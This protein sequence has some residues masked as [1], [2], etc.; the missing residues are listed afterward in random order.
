MSVPLPEFTVT[1]WWGPPTLLDPED[2]LPRVREAGFNV[3]NLP[4]YT[5]ADSRYE[6]SPTVEYNRRL[7]RAAEENG[8]RV[9]V[10][11]P[12]IRRACR[13]DA[14][15]SQ[16]R[17]L[18]RTVVSDYAGYAA[19]LGYYLA[20]EPGGQAFAPLAEVHARLKEAG[21]DALGYVNLLPNYAPAKWLGTDS[22]EEY[23]RRFAEAVRPDVLSYD[24]YRFGQMNS[25][26]SAHRDEQAQSTQPQF[27]DEIERLAYE[28]AHD[29]ADSPS[30]YLENLALFSRVSREYAIPF[31]LVGLLVTHGPYPYVP[32]PQIE[33]QMVHAVRYGARGFSYFSYWTPAHDDMWRW[34]DGAV[35]WDGSATGHYDDV[36]SVNQRVTNEL[37][38]RLAG[39][40]LV[41]PDMPVATALPGVAVAG[42]CRAAEFTGGLALV[43][44]VSLSAPAELWFDRNGAPDVIAGAQASVG[45]RGSAGGGGAITLGPGQAALIRRAVP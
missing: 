11:D 19:L 12:R 3:V 1:Y 15:S 24:H 39:N 42:V 27:R 22:Y 38:D 28:T 29:P 41:N 30:A 14:V 25:P 5:P 21:P 32:R 13:T 40:A 10:F 44:N 7:L 35:A 16:R 17:E 45:N 6:P 4:V 43:Q 23:V 26:R 36:K 2:E 9:I 33:W 34:R 18:V 8:L 20:D 31:W 37:L